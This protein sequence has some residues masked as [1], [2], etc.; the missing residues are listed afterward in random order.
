MKKLKIFLY[1]IILVIVFTLGFI[2]SRYNFIPTGRVIDN[3][4]VNKLPSD[5]LNEDK[6]LVYDDKIVLKINNAQ[7]SNYD[8]SD[9]M[10]PFIGEGANGV[11]VKP[12]N[13][14]EVKAGDII[15]FKRGDKLIVHRVI[16]K[17]NDSEG[18]YFITKGDNSDFTD[19]KIRFNEI[20]HKLIGILY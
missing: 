17:G 3:L 15:T 19:G 10:G 8:S 14:G 16:E 13:E 5:Y 2:S 12:E 9:S 11:V 20:E 4:E 6:M 18:I 7:I 1:L